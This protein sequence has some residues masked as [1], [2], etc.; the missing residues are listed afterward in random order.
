MMLR[1]LLLAFAASVFYAP[2]SAQNLV[3]ATLLGNKT[4]SELIAQFNV[5][6]IQF[7]I[8]Y[9]K[10]L[11]TTPD[12]HGVLDTASG[13]LAVPIDD[14]RCFARLVYQHGTS[15][16]RQDVPS[17]NVQQNGEGIIGWLFAGLGYITLMPDYLGLGASRGFHPY[18]HAATEASAALDMLRATTDYLGQIPVNRNHQLFIT[19][20]SQGGHG[21]MALHRAIEKDSTKEFSVVAAAPMSGPYSIGEAMHNLILS[22]Q[23]YFYPAYIP[24]TALSYQTAY[25]N[26]FTQLTDIF[27]P[28]YAALIDKFWKN[29]ITLSTLNDELIKMLVLNEGASRPIK[30]LQD[31][32]IEAVMNNP[33]HP[34]NVALRAN[35]TYNNWLPKAPMRLFYCMA[36][37]QVPFQNSVIARDSLTVVGAPNFQALDVNPSANHNGCVV[38]ALTNT[39]FFFAGLQE[40][41][42]IVDSESPR[43][44]SLDMAPNPAQEE[45][46]IRG[47]EAAGELQILDIQGQVQYR[48]VLSPG[49]HT[50]NLQALANG[51]YVVQ[52]VS[53]GKVR[54]GKLVIGR[55]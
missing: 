20:Y 49:D 51:V 7:D 1:A 15:G 26:I 29:E 42:I 35:N 53:S 34:I 8:K 39:I 3:S 45:V 31:T 55:L 37:D 41:C 27:K 6:F 22:D 44:T 24:N 46:Q 36:D 12:V 9:Y 17:V 43:T 38:P 33:N 25:G 18:V 48:S 4:A 19:G 50:L 40:M 47:L 11:Y 23:V 10:V 5:P 13:L 52:F 30:M 21:A 54:T 32:T 28:S 14:Q 16:S 2:L